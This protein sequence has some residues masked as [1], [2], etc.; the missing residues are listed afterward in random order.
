MAAR[1]AVATDYLEAQHS[2]LTSLAL[3]L[4]EGVNDRMRYPALIKAPRVPQRWEQDC[5]DLAP[6]GT[7]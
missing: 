7:G 5:L 3:D 1:R 2:L 4:A 6:R